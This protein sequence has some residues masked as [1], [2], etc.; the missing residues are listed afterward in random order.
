MWCVKGIVHC[1][2]REGRE[3]ESLAK[4]ATG[5]L[6][7]KIWTNESTM[8]ASLGCYQLKIKW[9]K[10]TF[11]HS[12]LS[13]LKTGKQQDSSWSRWEEERRRDSTLDSIVQSK[14]ARCQACRFHCQCLGKEIKKPNR[15]KTK[16]KFKKSATCQTCRFHCQC[17]GKQRNWKILFSWQK[18]ILAK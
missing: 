9:W 12:G 8:P 3:N 16:Q 10:W 17:L 11:Q 2:G 14:P 13:Q 18:A 15:C 7:P 5:T 4:I 1:G 6:H